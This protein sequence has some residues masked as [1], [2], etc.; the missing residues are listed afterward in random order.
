MNA[1]EDI[2]KMYLEEEGY[3]V[4]QSVKVDITKDDKKALGLPSMPRPEI[5]IVAIKVKDNELLLVEVKSFLDSYGVYW[6]VV[7]GEIDK[8]DEY[9]E[10]AKH[11]RL[12]TNRKFRKIVTQRL[13][14]AYLKIGLIN[15]R[16]KINYAFAVGKFH[17]DSEERI[18]AYF[19]KHG[20]NWKL[21]APTDIKEWIRKLSDKGWEDNLVIMTSKLTKEIK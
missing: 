20:R 7:C 14:E 5:D 18:R 9:Y 10:V 1:F 13:R 16:T 12:F 8:N 4:R 15:E 6:Q 11:Y 19:S 3:W 17:S 21:F 2:I